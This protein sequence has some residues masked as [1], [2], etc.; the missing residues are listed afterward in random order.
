LSDIEAGLMTPHIYAC[1]GKFGTHIC[2]QAG[3]VDEATELSDIE[4]G[5]MT[6]HNKLKFRSALEEP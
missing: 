2:L 6:P 1:S 3:S 5:L 4:T